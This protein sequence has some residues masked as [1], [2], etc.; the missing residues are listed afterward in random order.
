MKRWEWLVEPKTGIYQDPDLGC[1]TEDS[2]ALVHFA[3]IGK[4]DAVLDLGTGNGVLCLY[5]ETRY[6]G[7]YT[8]VDVDAE[9][10]ALARASAERNGQAIR[11][12]TLSAEDA[13]KELCDLC[14]SF[15]LAVAETLLAKTRRAFARHP[16]AK[17]L[18][19]AGGVT[20]NS[21]VRAAFQRFGPHW[22][23]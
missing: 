14:A 5:A 23:L 21:L 3:R 2:I 16:E 1:F 8:G 13:P 12:L 4:S 7:T 18:L 15:N 19:L 9:Q 11:F 6:G 22:N 17:T 10:L 20:A